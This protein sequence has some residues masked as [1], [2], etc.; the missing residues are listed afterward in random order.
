MK[1]NKRNNKSKEETIFDKISSVVINKNDTSTIAINE[2]SHPTYISAPYCTLED[3]N[4]LE[5]TVSR[6]VSSVKDLE[7]HKRIEKRKR[8]INA[9]RRKR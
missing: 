1:R 9:E 7:R 3:A 4:K 8:W 5:S 6:L 2:D